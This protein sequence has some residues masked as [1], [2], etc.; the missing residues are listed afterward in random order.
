MK[1][2]NNMNRTVKTIFSIL[3]VAVFMLAFKPNTPWIAPESAK[4]L[5]NPLK[6]DE[7]TIAEGKKIYA[8]ECQSC[9]GKRGE[10]DGPGSANLNTQMKSFTE[11]EFKKQSDGEIFWKAT[12]GRGEMPAGKKKLSETQ[13]WQ[14]VLFMRTLKK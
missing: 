13:R 5:V 7:L 3:V 2:K 11:A 6:A 1:N 9:H 10:G 8:K 14:T 4:K 12:E